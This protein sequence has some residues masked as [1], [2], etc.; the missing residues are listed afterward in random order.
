MLGLQIL[1]ILQSNTLNKQTSFKS[2]TLFEHVFVHNLNNNQNQFHLQEM[3]SLKLSP[4]LEMN[5]LT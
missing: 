1:Q 3:D 4:S 2:N 5:S